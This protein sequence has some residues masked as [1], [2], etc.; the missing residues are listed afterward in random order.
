M[1]GTSEGEEEWAWDLLVGED[2]PYDLARPLSQS[3]VGESAMAS[4]CK[5]RGHQMAEVGVGI[6]YKGLQ[7]GWHGV[8][9]RY[10]VA[11][12]SVVGVAW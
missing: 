12:Q 4:N 2:E 7:H 6:V 11:W 1:V 10:D 3:S 9:G 5:G 8:Y